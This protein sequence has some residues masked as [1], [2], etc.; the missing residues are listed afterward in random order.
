[1]EGVAEEVRHNCEN[2]THIH[3]KKEVVHHLGDKVDNASTFSAT[4]AGGTPDTS[5]DDWDGPCSCCR[6]EKYCK[7]GLEALE[8]ESNDNYRRRYLRCPKRVSIQVFGFGWLP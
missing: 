2:Q 5:E 8:R 7:C 1:M 6:M 3:Y 4:T